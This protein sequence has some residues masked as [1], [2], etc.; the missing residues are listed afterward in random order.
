MTTPET[1]EQVYPLRL[2]SLVTKAVGFGIGTLL[3]AG[4]TVFVIV[5]QGWIGVGIFL[6]LTTLV[7]F[8]LFLDP[9]LKMPQSKRVAVGISH[10]G[11]RIPDGKVTVPWEDIE[12]ILLVYVYV[13]GGQN[14]MVAHAVGGNS[15]HVRVMRRGGEP[16]VYV[17]PKARAYHFADETE[18]VGGRDAFIQLGRELIEWGKAKGVRVALLAAA[19]SPLIE[20]LGYPPMAEWTE[21]E[22]QAP[23]S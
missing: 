3:A 11:L 21:V 16:F 7:I 14:A 18:L 17:G 23:T 5:V 6:A 12:R 20:Q 13:G 15:C 9:V 8:M 19:D 4:V 22:H 2:G 1:A 10:Q